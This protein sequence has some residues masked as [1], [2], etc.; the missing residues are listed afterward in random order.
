M[1][2]WPK[3]QQNVHVYQRN[4]KKQSTYANNSILL[5]FFSQLLWAPCG[6]TW[7]RSDQNMQEPNFKQKQSCFRLRE[8]L[9]SPCVSKTVPFVSDMFQLPD[10][11]TVH[12]VPVTNSA[13]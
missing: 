10:I 8:T 7:Q 3:Y 2:P 11:L 1:V 12:S 13:L 4:H 5:F 6:F 9:V